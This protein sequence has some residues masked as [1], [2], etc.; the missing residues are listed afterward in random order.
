[1]GTGGIIEAFIIVGLCCG[2]VSNLT[3]DLVFKILYEN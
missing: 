2:A 1:V 3:L